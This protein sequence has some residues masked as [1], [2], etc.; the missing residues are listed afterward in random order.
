M[1]DEILDLVFKDP[2]P[3][4]AEIE[5]KYPPRQLPEG[6]IVTRVGPSPTGLLHIGTLNAALIP[7][8]LA[9]A[10]GGVFFLRIEDTDQKR[11]VAE[12]TD[13]ILKAFKDY[14]ICP[15]EGPQAD[16]TQKGAYGPYIQS[17]RKDIYQAYAKELLR[18]DKA[19]LC[20]CSEESLAQAHE[21]Q[22]KA[23]IRPGYYGPFA[24]C[25][26]LSEDAV[27]QNLK[28]GKP[29]IVR[30]KSPGHYTQKIIIHD[31]VRGKRELP[32][33]DLDVPILKSDG[34]PTYHFAHLIDDHLMGTTHVMRGEEWLSSLPLHLQMFE[35]MGWQAPNYIHFSHILKLDEQTGNKRKISKRYDPEA[36]VNF[37]DEQGYPKTAVIE[38]LLTLANSNFEDWR[39][40]NPDASYK[41][42]KL[43]IQKLNSSGA[44][45]D[46]AKLNS[47]C[48]E[49]I[50]KMTAEEIYDATWAWAKTYRPDFATKLEQ[51]KAYMIDILNIERLGAKKVRKDLIKWSDVETETA[52]FF[53]DSFQPA[54]PYAAL[55]PMPAETVKAIV[56]DFAAL[57]DAQDDKDTWFAK[58]KQVAEKNGFCA[59]MKAYKANPT[60]FKGSVADVAKVLRV[61]ITGKEQSPDLH[62][63][64]RVLGQQATLKRLSV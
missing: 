40:A 20:F 41:E 12:A 17:Q 31:L 28:D 60:A 46:L 33:N 36:C 51:N 52:F 44:L 37:Y 4:I 3:T 49:H 13:V 54:D 27:L 43:S 29:F 10:C 50:G 48:R 42:F 35:A 21:T 59:D 7:Y 5:A 6:A 39:R 1:K 47:I 19:Y 18:Q 45:F 14:D 61:F 23:K 30:F 16:G 32:Q 15:D 55:A 8:S 25:R 26:T 11:Q 9:R 64:M 38:Y 57:Y 24:R 2:L 63:V 58:I 22:V 62:A 34:L 56:T 53:D